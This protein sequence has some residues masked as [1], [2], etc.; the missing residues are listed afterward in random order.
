[1]RDCVPEG[2][3]HS[4]LLSGASS[5]RPLW[6]LRVARATGGQYF[7]A[8]AEA[9]KKV[10]LYPEPVYYVVPAVDRVALAASVFVR[11]ASWLAALR[12]L[13]FKLRS[14]NARVMAQRRA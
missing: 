2:A 5:P 7:C 13:V 6:L 11:K 3:G 1:M 12:R 10:S 8:S 4:R 14:V 9:G